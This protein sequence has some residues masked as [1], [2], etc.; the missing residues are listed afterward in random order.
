MLPLD[1]LCQGKQDNVMSAN[2]G[3]T[4]NIIKIDSNCKSYGVNDV[5]ILSIL[6]KKK[7]C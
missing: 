3:I 4:R 2:E 7:Q 5:F 1:R 6:V